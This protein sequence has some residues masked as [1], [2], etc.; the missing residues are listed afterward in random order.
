MS[1]QLLILLYKRL[2][3]RKF[4]TCD[5]FEILCQKDE[6]ITIYGN[7]IFNHYHGYCTV[8]RRFC[9]IFS[10]MAA[11][12]Q[13]KPTQN[14]KLDPGQVWFTASTTNKLSSLN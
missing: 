4:V 2:L 5:Q 7:M 1:H 13:L 12:I 8:L 10:C 6:F 14:V 11:W 3:L 9:F